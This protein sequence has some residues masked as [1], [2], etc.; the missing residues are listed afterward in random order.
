MNKIWTIHQLERQAD[1]GFVVNV[2]LRYAF[3]ETPEDVGIQYYADSYGVISYTQEEGSD[4]IPYEDLTEE[5]VIGW[6]KES[7]DLEAIEQSL[8]DQIESQKNPPIL[9][10]LPWQ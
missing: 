2:H 1:N 8:E 9:Q 5:I 3:A 7:I 4:L 10:G 6:V